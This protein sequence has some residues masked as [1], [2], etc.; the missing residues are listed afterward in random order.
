M[1]RTG[2]GIFLIAFSGVGIYMTVLNPSWW[3]MVRNARWLKRL[4]EM[5]RENEIKQTNDKAII[6][7]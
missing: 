3:Q 2:I 4:E 5:N 1:I 7:K 6:E